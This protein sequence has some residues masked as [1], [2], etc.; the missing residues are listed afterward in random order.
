[1]QEKNRFFQPEKGIFPF[2]T[3]EKDI[4]NGESLEELLPKILFSS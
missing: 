1:M 2:N 4:D 3:I